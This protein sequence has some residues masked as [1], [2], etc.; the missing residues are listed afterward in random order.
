MNC[1]HALFLSVM[2]G[3][4]CTSTTVFIL[5]S[6]DLLLSLL[7]T[8]QVL[9]YHHRGNT[10][11]LVT[12]VQNLVLSEVVEVSIPLLFTTCF[13]LAYFGPNNEVLGNIGNSYFH[14]SA[15]E[16]IWAAFRMLLII[17]G[18][19]FTLLIINFGILYKFAGVNCLKVALVSIFPPRLK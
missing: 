14:Y 17:M 1:Y 11:S 18:I 7:A 19:D 10:T 8:L 13:M 12:A 3:G 6:I 2:A 5:L 15:V 4:L 9:Y 16:D